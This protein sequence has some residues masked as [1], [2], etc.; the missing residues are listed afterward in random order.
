MPINPLGE[1]ITG[2]TQATVSPAPPAAVTA[3]SA[4]IASMTIFFGNGTYVIEYSTGR[5]IGPNA[6]PPAGLTQLVTFVKGF[7]ETDQGW[8]PGSS[9]ST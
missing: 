6:F 7:V 1:T 8:A 9:V 4:I 3:A 5:R 2:P